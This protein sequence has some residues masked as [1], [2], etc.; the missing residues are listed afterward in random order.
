[1]V[2][3]WVTIEFTPGRQRYGQVQLLYDE[4]I[5]VKNVIKG[6]EFSYCRPGVEIK[7][8]WLTADILKKNGFYCTGHL[9]NLD[10]DKRFCLDI[11]GHDVTIR[12]NIGQIIRNTHVCYI[13]YVH[14]LQHF[15][16]VMRINKEIYL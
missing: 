1:M 7:P 6:D 15:L 10:D 12:P 5:I 4:K 8:V 2:N 3:D 13:S 9:F 14:E 11:M 16:K